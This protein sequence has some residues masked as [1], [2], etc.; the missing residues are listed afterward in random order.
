MHAAFMVPARSGRLHK[1]LA[2]SHQQGK[3]EIERLRLV[4][5]GARRGEFAHHPVGKRCGVGELRVE[6]KILMEAERGFR[7]RQSD[8]LREERARRAFR[9]GA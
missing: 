1:E 5:E 6:V 8:S 9:C 7:F 2:P 3:E 4:V